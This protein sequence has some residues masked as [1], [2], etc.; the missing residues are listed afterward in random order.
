LTSIV[1]LLT[2]YQRL[3]ESGGVLTNWKLPSVIPIYKK[4][5]REEPGYCRPVNLTSNPGKI[6]ENIV[7]GHTE[8]HSFIL[9]PLLLP[10]Q[11]T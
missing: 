1:N 8:S 7:L 6:M 10:T 11:T 3:W 2:I 4:G 5:I 9:T